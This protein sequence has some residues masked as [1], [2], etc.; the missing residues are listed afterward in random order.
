M[1][2]TGRSAAV[3]LAVISSIVVF[4]QAC[5]DGAQQSKSSGKDKPGLADPKKKKKQK[6]DNG[7][8]VGPEE[9][10]DIN[11]DEL[12]SSND[13]SEELFQARYKLSV[14][15]NIFGGPTNLCQGEINLVINKDMSMT[16]P[17]S[18]LSCAGSICEVDMQALQTLLQKQALGSAGKAVQGLD[19]DQKFL[20]VEKI[21][22]FTFSPARPVMLLSPFYFEPISEALK[23]NESYQG[24]VVDNTTGTSSSGTIN[25]RVTEA[26]Q[27]RL[28]WTMET[29]GWDGI[30]R[31]LAALVPKFEITWGLNPIQV[32]HI[33]IYTVI[34]DIIKSTKQGGAAKTSPQELARLCSGATGEIASTL[35]GYLPDEN[36]TGIFASMGRGIQQLGERMVSDVVA[37]LSLDL[38]SQRV[39]GQE[40]E[41]E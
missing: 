7:A 9:D 14:F 41:P 36:D 23:V 24:T 33:G 20:S 26:N 10:L 28:S 3:L 15:A 11:N 34:G 16:F 40:Q 27:D 30:A 22:D 4:G 32:P 19:S 18:S 39:L 31:P 25:L 12:K 5:Q 13:D 2:I 21:G 17:Q 6:H 1:R 37:G 38:I 35:A 8:F 29:S